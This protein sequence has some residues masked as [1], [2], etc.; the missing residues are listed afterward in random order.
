[1]STPSK[2]NSHKGSN[3]EWKHFKILPILP[4]SKLST[5]IFSNFTGFDN[6]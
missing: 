1:M 2:I 5:E 6:F 4:E 3:I